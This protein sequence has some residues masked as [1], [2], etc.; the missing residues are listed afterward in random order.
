[1]PVGTENLIRVT[2]QSDCDSRTPDDRVS[3][4]AAA[5]RAYPIENTGET[6]GRKHSPASAGDRTEPQ[7]SVAGAAQ[8]HRSADLRLAEP[9]ISL[10]SE[11]DHCGQ[12]RD[13][14]S[15]ASAR[16]SHLLALEIQPSWWPPEDRS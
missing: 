2:G 13:R 4:Q 11:C 6:R 16:L 8:E 15:V 14:Y 7:G 3:D 12:A 5:R 9:N 1:M 10:D